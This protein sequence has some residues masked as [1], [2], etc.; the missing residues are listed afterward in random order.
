MVIMDT[1]CEFLYLA[2]HIHIPK[3]LVLADIIVIV[4]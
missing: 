3:A 4:K 2:S 1:G